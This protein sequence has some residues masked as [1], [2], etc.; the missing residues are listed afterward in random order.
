[1][2]L[3]LDVRVEQDLL[4]GDLDAGLE[5]GRV[6]VVRAGQWAAAAQRVLLALDGS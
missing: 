2:T 5:H 3:G 1:M 6:P 4:A